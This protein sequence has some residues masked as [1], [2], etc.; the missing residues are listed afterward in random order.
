MH[1]TKH[2]YKMLH[3]QNILLK[4][5]EKAVQHSIFIQKKIETSESRTNNDNSK[6]V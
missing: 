4:Y 1:L 2:Y 5:G 6:N 3:N